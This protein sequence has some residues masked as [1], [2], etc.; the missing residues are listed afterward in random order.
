M[1]MWVSLSAECDVCGKKWVAV[2]QAGT[3]K[4]E[5]PNPDCGF[6]NTAPT[7]GVMFDHDQDDDADAW[8]RD[9]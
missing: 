9:A 3:E 6:M 2:F 8:K 5:C 4:L 7:P 1:V